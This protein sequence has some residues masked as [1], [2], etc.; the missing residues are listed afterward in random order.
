MKKK[1]YIDQ[2]LLLLG[3]LLLSLSSFLCGSI[4]W[5]EFK[6]RTNELFVVVFFLYACCGDFSCFFA[7]VACGK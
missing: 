4:S 6:E 7:T 3:G 1:K 5:K 2:L